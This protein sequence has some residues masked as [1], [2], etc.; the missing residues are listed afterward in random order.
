MLIRIH[1]GVMRSGTKRQRE[2]AAVVK[3]LILQETLETGRRLSGLLS[4]GL[5]EILKLKIK[6]NMSHYKFHE[7]QLL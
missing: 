3:R 5:V 1:E 7:M 4:C 2:V 6:V